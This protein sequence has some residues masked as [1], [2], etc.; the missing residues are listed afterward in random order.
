M[1]YAAT[2]P[3]RAGGR[4]PEAAKAGNGKSQWHLKAQGLGTATTWWHLWGT[5][6]PGLSFPRVGKVPLSPLVLPAISCSGADPR[7]RFGGLAHATL[8]TRA[9]ELGP[10]FERQRAGWA[11]SRPDGEGALTCS[12]SWL[13]DQES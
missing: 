10:G 12:L 13:P 7:G 3:Q 6:P 11:A 9:L 2:P 8:P 1:V 5:P 4:G